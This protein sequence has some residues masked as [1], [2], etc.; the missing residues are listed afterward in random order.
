MRRA[1]KIPGHTEKTGQDVS[2]ANSW[3]NAMRNLA[4][5]LAA[6]LLSACATA[7]LP[8]DQTKIGSLHILVGDAPAVRQMAESAGGAVSEGASAEQP[9]RVYWYLAGR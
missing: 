5:L 2:R 8:V 7:K 9:K 4:P 1:G 6:A 3:G